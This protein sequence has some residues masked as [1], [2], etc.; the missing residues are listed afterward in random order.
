[1]N[2]KRLDP[3][4][5]W[6]LGIVFALLPACQSHEGQS[7]RPA[8]AAHPDAPLS[9]LI[10]VSIRP[11]ANAP[12]IAAWVKREVDAFAR[13]ETSTPAAF[14]LPA[15]RGNG[16]RTFDAFVSSVP[17]K[18]FDPLTP[19]AGASAPRYGAF[20]DYVAW[21]GDGW[22][23]DWKDGVLGSP[24]QWSGDSARGWAWSNHEH[25][26]GV[27]PT[28]TSAPTFEHLTLARFLRAAGVLSNDVTA[29]KWKPADVDTH[30]RWA[31]RQ[32]GGSWF[33]LERDD[34]TRHWHAVRH[35]DAVR[36]DATSDTR[37]AITGHLPTRADHSDDGEPLAPGLASGIM[38][39]CSG[40]Q[41]PWG[42][43]FTAEEN[44]QVYYGDLENAWTTDQKRIGFPPGRAIA[45]SVAPS[46]S[47]LFGSMTAA[48]EL[49]DRDLYGWM[50]EIDPGEAPDRHYR[51][52]RAD[53]DGRGHRK[54]GA[55]G[56]ARW[57][58]CTVVVDRDWRLLDGEPIVL[59]GGNDRR[60][61]RVYKFV[62]REVYRRTMTRAETRALL[63]DGILYVAHFAGLDNRTGRTLAA[64]RALPTER[65]PGTGRWIRLDLAS[66][67]VAPNAAA[68][69][70]PETTVGEALRDVDWNGIG[71]FPDAAAVRAALFT[72]STKIGVMELNRPEDVEWNPR[73]PSGRPRLYVAFTGHGRR[74]ALD[75]RGVLFDPAEHARRSPRR[76][77]PGTIVALEEANPDAP[78]RSRTFTYRTAFAATIG[79]GA[80]DAAHPDNLLIDRDGGVWFTTDGNP[81]TN[82][83]ADGVY[84][85]DLDPTHRTKSERIARPSY[86]RAFRV[87]TVPHGAEATG[88]AFTPDMTTLFFHAQHPLERWPPR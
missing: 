47:G 88:P 79:D 4:R 76:L 25:L 59:Y 13:G 48:S 70:K 73:D 22:N 65:A 46:R 23:A 37:L 49:H 6:L 40:G 18:W 54:L 32:F 39:D 16:V 78:A 85:L 19:D 82:K 53:G 44:V 10:A 75:Q 20:G 81:G 33:R 77:D 26:L 3:G 64:T 56:R 84:Y 34:E 5:R 2:E 43:I 28:A 21:F 62:T 83:T 55:M 12:D 29:S 38:G 15:A 17:I 9:A 86:G 57:E 66:P 11:D 87:A 67:D 45:F 63:D 1:M 42:T 80:F 60:G 69:G 35:A 7:P 31:K 24:P 50:S 71:G 74:V 8:V 14:P 72:A 36:Y 41:T 61:G 51:S 58:N 30:L 68:L 52:A 27:P